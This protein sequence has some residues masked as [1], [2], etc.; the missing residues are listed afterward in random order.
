M[1]GTPLGVDVLTLGETMAAFRAPAPLRLGGTLSLSVA[2]AESNVAIGLARLGHRVSWIGVTGADEPGELIRRTLRAEGV[3]LT[4]AR[5]DPDAP[6]GLILFEARVGDISRVTYY[7]SGSAGSRLS[8]DDVPAA[9][10]A[11]ERKPRILHVTGITAGLGDQPYAAVV[12][13][14]DAAR[15]AGTLVCLDVNHRQRVWSVERAAAALRPL[16]PSIDLVVA[17]DDELGVLSD[18][19]DPVAALLAAGIPEVVV[20]HGGQGATSHTKRGSVHTPARSV[21]VLDTIGAGDAFVAGLLSG[22]L[23]RLDVADRLDR[24]VTTGAFAV[25]TRGDWEGLPTRAELSLLD[26]APGS[27]V[28]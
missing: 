7:R 12:A 27:A 21:P 11:A 18:H 13:A 22:L 26:H 17:S 16:L 9:F 20:K 4:L 5:V 28:R 2:G 3:D 14:V 24:A 1:T 15:A 8:V 25:A 6:T 19:P 10:A 23:D